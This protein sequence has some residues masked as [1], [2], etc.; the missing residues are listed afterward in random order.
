MTALNSTDLSHVEALFT[1][2]C[3]DP[4]VPR[5]KGLPD[6]LQFYRNFVS[7]NR[8]CILEEAC[9]SW[10]ALNRWTNEYLKSVGVQVTVSATPDG[11][12][13]AIRG[14]KFCLPYETQMPLAEFIDAIETPCLDEVL[15]IQKQNSNLENEFRALWKDIS[16]DVRDWGCRVFGVD[17]DAS[18]FWMGD[19]RAITSM[20]KDHYENL[21]AV[22]RGYKTFTLC[23]PHSI[24]R[25][26]HRLCQNF[27]YRRV[28]D[29]G[30]AAPLTDSKCFSS[31]RQPNTMSPLCDKSRWILEEAEGK[32]L[33]IDGSPGEWPGVHC[34]KVVL[35]M[36]DVL[37]LPSLW[38]HQVEQS[39]QCIAVNFWFDM[40]YDQRYCYFKM[41]E[42][43]NPTTVSHARQHLA[44]AVFN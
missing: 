31:G 39:H 14:D 4:E 9:A 8:P 32:T 27:V 42:L 37:Y 5:L 34:L 12:A 6:P 26:P 33:W 7:L 10:A 21:Y 25:I 17:P 15:Y 36:G 38:F 29:R 11:W 22:V 20:H 18:N 40:K 19:R 3:V 13:D 16:S 23:P 1:D 28:N 35:K 2:L 44:G 24:L 43:L 41:A 30:G